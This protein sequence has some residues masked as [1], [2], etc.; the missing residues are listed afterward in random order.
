MAFNVELQSVIS[1]SLPNKPYQ[2]YQYYK[3]DKVSG[4]MVKCGMYRIKQ[5]CIQ[6]L[7][8]KYKENTARNTCA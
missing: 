1:V 7:V 3:G 2:C 5:N 8:K 6:F 4:N